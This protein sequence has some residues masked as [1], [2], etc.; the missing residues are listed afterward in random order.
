M[1]PDT[2]ALVRQSWSRILPRR[3]EVCRAFY[4]RLFAVRPELRPLFKGDPE[5]QSA[6][7]VTMINTVIST[8]DDPRPVRTLLQ[9]LGARHAQ[10]G[11][12]AADCIE[13][14]TVLLE[15]LGPSFSPAHRVAWTAVFGQLSETMQRGGAAH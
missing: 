6:L 4:Q 2:A 15:A 3:K 13:F 12:A 10:Y 14:E 8:L 1:H 5:H 11:V 9:T 7:F